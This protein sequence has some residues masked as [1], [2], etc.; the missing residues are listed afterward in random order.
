MKILHTADWHLGKKLNDYSR[1]DEQR[2]VLEEICEI[3]EKENVDAVIIAG[4]LFDSFNPSNEAVELFYKTVHKL[5]KLGA[6]PVI[7]I[8]GNHDSADRVE[9]PDTLARECG[10]FLSGYPDTRLK[11]LELNTGLKITKTDAGF[12][13]LE[14]PNSKELL[15]IILTPYASESRLKSFFGVENTDKEFRKIIAEKWQNLASQY[16]D[17]NGVNILLTHLFMTNGT[18]LLD[19]PE[20]E[21]HILHVGGA[22]PVYTVDIPKEVDYTALGHLHRFHNLA[23]QE[24][25]PVIYSG[26]LLEYSLSETNQQKFVSI[27]EAKASASVSYNKIPLYSGKKVLRK[28]F[29]NFDDAINW[30]QEN[31]D[32][33]VELIL[34]S[35]TYINAALKKEIYRAHKGVLGIIPEIKKE[36]K[37]AE[38][39]QLD[40]SANIKDLF[41]QYFHSKFNQEANEEVLDLFEEIIHRTPEE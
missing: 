19:E 14:L 12:V 28:K 10:I 24:K 40:V 4:D 27:I 16:C 32:V 22:Q 30:L 17:K 18:D 34:V 15:R 37:E 35:D 8:A 25:P 23:S 33:Y 41:Q 1:I 3:A 2:E 11:A 38:E 39:K 9:A 26:S 6:C 31:Q 21:R 29:E 13:E 20:D 5:A 7:A 36:N